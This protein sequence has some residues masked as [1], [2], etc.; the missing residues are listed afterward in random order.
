MKRVDPAVVPP[1][2]TALL[3]EETYLGR[4]VYRPVKF[5][6]VSKTGRWITINW[7]NNR[8]SV[9]PVFLYYSEPLDIWTCPY[10]KDTVRRNVIAFS[11]EHQSLILAEIVAE[12]D[13]SDPGNHY[14][15]WREELV[16]TAEKM[17]D[18]MLRS[19]KVD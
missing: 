13:R 15:G 6:K 9:N 16:S 8:A 19:G 2:G 4:T 12:I 11:R 3:R 5:V 1:E 17:L 18:G 14:P 10:M 7:L